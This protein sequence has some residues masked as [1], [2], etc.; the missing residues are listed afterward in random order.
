MG[1][2][3]GSVGLYQKIMPL[4]ARDNKEAGS[5]GKM[6][7]ARQVIQNKV[8]LA[9]A[10]KADIKTLSLQMLETCLIYRCRLKVNCN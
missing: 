7:W 6:T 2:D 5:Q 4:G 3:S 10:C 1:V 9:N 8:C